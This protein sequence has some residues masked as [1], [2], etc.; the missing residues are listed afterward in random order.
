MARG[1]RKKLQG[2]RPLLPLVTDDKATEMLKA[3]EVW[4]RWRPGPG[5][6][7]VFCPFFS[8]YLKGT[9]V[10]V[11][12]KTYSFEVKADDGRTMTLKTKGVARGIENG[13]SYN[14]ILPNLLA[15]D[16]KPNPDNLKP[17]M[18]LWRL[19]ALSVITMTGA[20]EFRPVS[21][22]V[23]VVRLLPEDESFVYYY[24]DD[25]SYRTE[26]T[27][28]LHSIEAGRFWPVPEID[29]SGEHYDT[30]FYHKS[31]LPPSSRSFQKRAPAVG[32]EA[33]VSGTARMTL[34]DDEK[35]PTQAKN[36]TE[37]RLDAKMA[38]LKRIMAM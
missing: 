34:A 16:E 21:A 38:E 15:Q 23:R 4:W 25:S 10:S 12:E 2:T 29:N 36:E 18:L 31:T 30:V 26:Y 33:M 3:S 27:A 9:I 24:E 7:I 1:E 14:Y 19:R 37:K 22:A 11:D 32:Y 20:I 28:T 17:G 5:Q 35:R 13:V 8:D 6:R